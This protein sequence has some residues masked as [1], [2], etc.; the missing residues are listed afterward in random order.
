[1][2]SGRFGFDKLRSG[3]GMAYVSKEKMDK[4]IEGTKEY[5]AKK[6]NTLKK[7][8]ANEIKIMNEKLKLIK[9]LYDEGY[10]L[11][12]SPDSSNKYTASGFAML[13]EMKLY[14]QANLTNFQILKTA[15]VNFNNFVNENFGIIAEGKDADFIMTNANPL[16]NLNTL[17]NIE[18]VFINNHFIDKSQLQK[19]ANDL[20]PLN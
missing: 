10:N 2:G 19:M 13:Q 14:Q 9:R 15:T 16:K 3:Y 20:K 1:M 11:L 12:L 18:S 8:I 7:E 6:G 5:Q 4:W 17:K